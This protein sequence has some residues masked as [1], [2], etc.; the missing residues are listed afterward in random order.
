MKI[1]M[2]MFELPEYGGGV[3]PYVDD[4]YQG[5]RERGYQVDF[6]YAVGHKGRDTISRREH[7]SG[8]IVKLS[9][10][11]LA[12]ISKDRAQLS[13]RNRCTRY[14]SGRDH[15]LTLRNELEENYTD[16][17]VCNAPTQGLAQTDDW[18]TAIDVRIPKVCIAHDS[19]YL[20]NYPW[21]LKGRF[22]AFVSVHPGTFWA[23]MKFPTMN[24]CILNPFD[25]SASE[26]KL[27]KDW[28]LIC[29][30]SMYRSWK[31][32]EDG[33]RMAPF[34]SP[35]KMLSTGGGI[36]LSYLKAQLKPEDE[37]TGKSYEAY[38]MKLF[39]YTWKY[40]D[41]DCNPKWV[42]RR[43]WNVALDSDCFEHLGFLETAED[44]AKL[45]ARCGG[46]VDFARHNRGEHFNRVTVEGIIHRCIP[47]ARPRGV[48]D[49][50]EGRGIIFGPENIVMLPMDAGPKRM[51]EIIKSSLADKALRKEIAERNL[52]K[53]KLFDRKNVAVEFVK[54]LDGRMSV[55]VF[56]VH[57][58]KPDKNVIRKM[59]D[60]DIFPRFPRL[61]RFPR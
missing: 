4:L 34:L 47:F 5:F 23:M 31:H 41:E 8:K 17:I 12:K 24:C 39:H 38:R 53:L 43:I 55:G 36:E 56:G 27:E 50:D 59:R 7:F 49:N 16:L 15:A 13:A 60:L 51:A 6:L 44:V 22:D 52:E 40:A 61:K 30:T 2:L 14:F 42:G 10:G 21:I 45:Q 26:E 28:N 58:G 9:C 3:V 25:I 19:E 54:L 11:L 37:Y 57:H 33:I 48:S 29:N 18:A 35:V 32:N 1:A 46:Q 20:R